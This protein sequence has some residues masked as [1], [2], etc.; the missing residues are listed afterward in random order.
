MF[1]L[2]SLLFLIYLIS[3]QSIALEWHLEGW[4]DVRV[5][6]A[7]F[8]GSPQSHGKVSG[9]IWK[10]FHIFWQLISLSFV[11]FVLTKDIV[12]FGKWFVQ[13]CTSSDRLFGRRWVLQLS[14]LKGQ[15]KGMKCF[16]ETVPIAVNS[17]GTA[18]IHP[19]LKSFQ[20][21]TL[22]DCIEAYAV[23]SFFQPHSMFNIYVK[24]GLTENFTSALFLSL[25][26]RS[27]CH[28]PSRSSCMAIR[29]ALQSIYANILR[30]VHWPRSIWLRQRLPL[31]LPVAAV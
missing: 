4:A 19:R 26:A 24:R 8:Q 7:A 2:I 30:C 12:R 27:I 15:S 17:I 1:A 13:P 25:V 23:A 10:I 11:R 5:P 31:L 14:I 16:K 9:S 22:C 28:F 20:T 29:S 21:G 18:G 3:S 6:L